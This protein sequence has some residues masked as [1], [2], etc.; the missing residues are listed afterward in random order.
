MRLR[1]LSRIP[2]RGS[3]LKT[4]ANLRGILHYQADRDGNGTCDLPV[5]CCGPQRASLGFARDLTWDGFLRCFAAR[6]GGD[7]HSRAEKYGP[8]CELAHKRL[9]RWKQIWGCRGLSA[10]KVSRSDE[11]GKSLCCFW[12]LHL[13]GWLD[14]GRISRRI[15]ERKRSPRSGMPGRY[16]TGVRQ[17]QETTASADAVQH[18][19]ANGRNRTASLLVLQRMTLQ[20]AL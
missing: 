19:R 11:T 4:A 12:S 18:V 7:A 5:D 17:R 20:L 8:L 9:A 2:A 1:S 15:C 14:A 13:C 16:Q 10:R 3:T 6:C